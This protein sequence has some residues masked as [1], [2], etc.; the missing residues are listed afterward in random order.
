MLH[1]LE[2]GV[3]LLE[4]EQSGLCVGFGF[5]VWLL[6]WLGKAVTPPAPVAVQLGAALV[7][8]GWSDVRERP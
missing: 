7:G 8:A 1:A 4:V 5:H 2:S 3:Q 6:K